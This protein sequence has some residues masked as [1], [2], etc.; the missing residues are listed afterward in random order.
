[1]PRLRSAAALSLLLASSPFLKA[2]TTASPTERL[3][4]EVATHGELMP[5][6]EHLCDDLGPRLTGSPRLRQAQAWAL[7][8]LRAY[9]ATNVHEEAYELG[10]PWSRGLT[11]ARL[12]NANGQAL[13]LVQMAWTEGTKGV[14]RGDVAVLDVKTLAEFKAL[15]PGL[16]GKVVLVRSRPRPTEEELK[17]LEGY[18]A[19]ARK[20]WRQARMALALLPSDKT[21]G[22]HEMAGGPDMFYRERAA[23]I[24]QEDAH[25]L[26]RLLA[27]GITPRVEAEL[28]GTF[29]KHPVKA[30]NVVGE[31]PGSERPE[32]VVILGAHQ[33]SWDLSPGATD[34]GAGT[35]VAM[36]V[37]RAYVATGL[38]PKRTLR[39]VLFSGEEQG[40]LGSKAYL[41]AH[42]AARDRIQ[43][44][45]VLDAGAGRVTG[46]VDMQVDAWAAALEKA[47]LPANALGATDVPYAYSDGSDQAS[48]AAQGVPAFSAVQDPGDYFT[49]THHSQ[50]D[51]VDHVAKED[52]VQAT[53]VL[54][55]TAWGL[56]HG[57]RLP[58]QVV[59]GK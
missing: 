45:L 42:A 5:N 48:F 39:V 58:H 15:A 54:A 24:T 12:L 22:L 33:D 21:F 25:L 2:Q 44:V 46:F 23:F 35:V 47:L 11:R 10:R 20:A 51:T 9:G 59:T 7:A 14:V 49:H 30:Y 4:Q 37:L 43:A 32:E 38:K 28:G 55:V 31:I 13:N 50:V 36:E 3:V 17:D 34:N 19:E 6:L 8:K 40:L 41:A 57:E 18:R 56:L 16:A 29:G 52:L 27:R 1:M 26:Q 53:Q